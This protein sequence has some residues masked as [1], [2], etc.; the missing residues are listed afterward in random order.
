MQLLLFGRIVFC[1]SLFTIGADWAVILSSGPVVKTR[2]LTLNDW[3]SWMGWAKKQKVALIA[4]CSHCL[5]AGE[6]QNIASNALSAACN[7]A[8]ELGARVSLV[9][10][11]PWLG[12]CRSHW[13]QQHTLTPA[14]HWHQQHTDTSSTH[15]HQQNTDTS[16]THWH[17]Q[18][19][20]TSSTLTPTA[21]WHQQHTLTPAAHTDTSSAVT[22]AA[23]WRTLTRWLSVALRPQKL[24]AYWGREPRTAT[25]T[26]TQTSWA[27]TLTP[28]RTPRL[29]PNA[30]MC[31]VVTWVT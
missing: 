16:S 10:F 5:D 9:I 15:W 30:V 8:C 11:P 14:A 18:N 24:Y 20:D 13:H 29:H 2:G 31:C 17:Q 26:L 25:S 6:S 21:H 4:R 12:L 27:L 28:E 7:C 23:H 19:T 1:P 3:Q 22:P